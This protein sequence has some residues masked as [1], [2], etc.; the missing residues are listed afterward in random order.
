[1]I[2]AWKGDRGLKMRKDTA[3]YITSAEYDLQT[4]QAM[5]DSGRY[6]YVIFMCHISIEKMLKAIAAEVT[7]KT[8]PKTH[9]LIYL[10]KL[11]KVQFSQELFDFVAKI[12]NV[13]VITRYPEDFSEILQAYPQDITQEYLI[14]TREVIKC[15]KENPVLN[16]SS[17]D[18]KKN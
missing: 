16:V 9:N 12:N 15:L 13:S 4:A 3:N 8:P 10:I 2:T 14:R 11:A 7:G 6:L 18:I 17:K 5:L 1:M